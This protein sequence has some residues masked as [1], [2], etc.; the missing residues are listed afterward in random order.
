[1]NTI[2]VRP[3]K[4]EDLPAVFSLIMD[5]AT[6]EKS[7]H[8]VTNTPERFAEDF[9]A[10]RFE[11]WVAEKDQEEVVGMA[12]TYLRYS[13]WRG[14]CLYLEDLYVRPESRGAGAGK[15]LLETLM[16]EAQR[17]GYPLIVWQVLDWNQPAIDFYQSMGA[18][19]QSQW[20][21]CVWE[22]PDLPAPPAP[23]GEPQPPV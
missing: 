21:N 22:N 4:P 9:A 10:E 17:K 16:E 12:L 6:Y 11:L 15:A 3:G 13:T 5:L 14:T 19:M 2:E 7:P 8:L 23:E 20:V 18:F 1:M